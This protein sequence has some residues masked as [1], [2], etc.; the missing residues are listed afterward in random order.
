[1]FKRKQ[2]LSVFVV[3][4]KRTLGL[5]D[6]TVASVGIILGAGIYALIGLAAQSSGN[7][8][9]LSFLI[10]AIIAIFTGLSY[11]ELSSMFKGDAGEYDYLHA[12][13]NKPFAFVM[14]FFVTAVGGQTLASTFISLFGGS[15]IFLAGILVV[16]LFMTM[17]GK[18]HEDL[19]KNVGV[20]V[21]LVII[22][23]ALFLA[24]TG[25][26][27][28]LQIDS[29][30]SATVFWLIIILAVIYLVTK[31]KAETTAPAPKTG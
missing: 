6:V 11:A 16:V 22:G 24:S 7:A 18:T 31:E 27:I 30:I 17:V 21:V 23:A 13:F 12:A 26:I 2:I 1:M 29:Q 19:G 20:L 25:N 15:A 5:F 9:W 8:T 28:G 10:T 4:L 14:A 3:G